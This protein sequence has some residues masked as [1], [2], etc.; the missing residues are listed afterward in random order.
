MKEQARVGRVV[1][2]DQ[3]QRA[4]GLR[5]S[6]PRQDVGGRP[7]RQHP[8][9]Q[10]LAAVDV[11]G[12]QGRCDPGHRRGGPPRPAAGEPGERRGGRG[13]PCRLPEPAHHLLSLESGLEAALGE[14]PRQHTRGPGLAVGRRAAV[15]RR[16]PI[17]VQ[18]RL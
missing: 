3:H 6:R 16:E 1:M 9:Q 15:H 5:V 2:G 13:E 17:H 18:A 14:H 12:D 4:L 8:P 11:V 10:V 7:F